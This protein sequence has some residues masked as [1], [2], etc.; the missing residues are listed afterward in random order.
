MAKARYG[1]GQPW[2]ERRAGAQRAVADHDAP[3]Q[4]YVVSRYGD[5]QDG[6]RAQG[7]AVTRAVDH[8]AGQLVE[9]HAA[10]QDVL[11]RMTALASSVRP[12]RPGDWTRSRSERAASEAARVLDGGGELVPD[13]RDPTKPRHQQPADDDADMATVARA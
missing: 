2:A 6:L 1:A 7:E 10:W 13:V 11:G 4:G 9:A 12:T 8:A 3:I 5:L